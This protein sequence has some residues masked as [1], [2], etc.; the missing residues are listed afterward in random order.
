MMDYRR[1]RSRG[2]LAYGLLSS[3]VFALDE[4]EGIFLCSAWLVGS[5]VEFFLLGDG[6]E[7]GLVEVVVV[8]GSGVVAEE[9]LGSVLELVDL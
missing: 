4:Y 2:F 8:G 5:F 9:L 6:E 1:W 3:S 7:V